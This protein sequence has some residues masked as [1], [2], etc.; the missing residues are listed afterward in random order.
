MK[1]VVAFGLCIMLMSLF[2]GDRGLPAVWKARRQ[3]G[4]LGREIGMLRAENAMLRERARALRGDARTIERAARE[5]L[6]LARRDEL[7]VRRR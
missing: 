6:G 3:A 7:V 4:A 2:A 5:S 1:T